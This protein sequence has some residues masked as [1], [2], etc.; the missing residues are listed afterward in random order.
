MNFN[1]KI[2]TLRKQLGLSQE[3]LGEKVNVSRQTVSKWELGETKPEFDKLILLS[4]LFDISIDDLVNSK[5]NPNDI[6][7]KNKV[8]A[9][10]L[11]FWEYEYQSTWR[12]GSLPFVHI[13]IGRGVRVASGIIAIGNIARGVVAIGMIALGLFAIA[14]LALGVLALGALSFGL[15][16]AVGGVAIGSIVIGGVACGIIAVGGLSFGFYAIGGAAFAYNV[17]FGGYANGYIAIG[18]HLNGVVTFSTE[19]A[20][21]FSEVEQAIRLHF[22]NTWNW[23][24]EI[25]RLLVS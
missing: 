17:A 6:N 20:I 24:I 4:E 13:N 14:P 8:V 2:I 25:F 7:K 11:F 9:G 23:I 10:S 15:V 21:H 3:Q 12:V 19:E 22:P 5:K 18:E 16:F 1:E